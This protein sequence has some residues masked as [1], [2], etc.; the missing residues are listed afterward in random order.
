[1]SEKHAQRNEGYCRE[2]QVKGHRPEPGYKPF[3]LLPEKISEQDIGGG[4]GRRPSKI[5]KQKSAQRHLRHSSQKIG[6]NGRKQEDEARNKN[7]LG[8]VTSEKLF[9]PLQV[10]GREVEPADFFQSG[11]PEPSPQPEGTNA[12]QKTGH[13]SSHNRRPQRMA[14]SPQNKSCSQKN[15]FARQR[16]A[17]VIQKRDD[18]D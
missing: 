15:C 1:M 3:P 16:H 8:T 18:E 9:G 17:E 7:C 4:I 13:R 6:H 11:Q 12:A 5:E 2:N 14:S 10:F